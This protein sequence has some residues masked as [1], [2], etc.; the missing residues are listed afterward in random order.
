MPHAVRFVETM[1]GT[2]SPCPP[3]RLPDWYDD[4]EG[5]DT[6]VVQASAGMSDAATDPAR[7]SLGVHDLALAVAPV[8][9]GDDGLPGRVWAG[10]VQVGEQRYRVDAGRFL[11][12][13]ASPVHGRRLRYRISGRAGTGERVDLA[14]VKVVTGRPWRWWADTSRM[15]V[16]LAVSTEDGELRSAAAGTVRLGMAAFARQMTTLRGRPMDVLAF[17]GRFVAR[18]VFPP[19][20]R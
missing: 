13:A 3:A 16:Y 12:L 10:T 9:T 7:T 11:A 20:R 2:V 1:T 17:L 4:P 19:S 8:A 14:G 15:Y 5:F 18:L 6:R